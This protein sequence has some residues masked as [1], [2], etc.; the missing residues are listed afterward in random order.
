MK[1]RAG[2]QRYLRF[3]GPDP[4]ADVDEEL[5]FH[6]EMRAADMQRRGHEAA[7]AREI[8][9]SRFGD[10]AAVRE[11]MVA[12]D[13]RRQRQND[14]TESMD[15]FLLDLRYA[16]RKLGQ[17]RSFTLSVVTVLALGIGAATAM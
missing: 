11:W 14:R 9:Q 5:E 13:R 12:H 3:W 6:L 10:V 17:Q 16:L 8:A 15:A 1:P 2:W 7:Q 4:E